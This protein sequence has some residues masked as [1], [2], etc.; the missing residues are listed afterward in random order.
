VPTLL[1]ETALRSAL[2]SRPF[3]FWAQVGST[4]D[5]ARD[6][7]LAGAP[8]GSVVVTE[9][10]LSGRGRFGRAWSAPA[11]TALLIS[12]IL[13]PRIEGQRLGRMTMVG[14][15]SV[16]DVLIDLVPDRVSLK[17][18]NDV[19]LAGR[20]TAGILPEA[21][22]N[23]GT[24]VAVIMGIGLNVS[25]DFSGTPLI[26]RATSIEKVTGQIVDR[27][28][29]L[30]KLL[31]RLDYWSVRVN[32]KELFDLWR[33]RLGMFGQRVTAAPVT[34]SD[35]QASENPPPTISGE[36]T[37]VDEDGALILKTDD[38]TLHRVISGEVTLSQQN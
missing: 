33:E 13:R 6:W 31:Q 3:Q 2:G 4:N 1:T 14:A 22:W 29:L 12:T 34:T 28:Q 8:A 20:K 15:V 25:V 38:G 11:G 35:T 36:A 26:D 30:N 10:Q 37:D 23:G 19:L 32:E 18:P 21:L 17:W 27:P 7:A 16:S 5:L 9:E 24:L